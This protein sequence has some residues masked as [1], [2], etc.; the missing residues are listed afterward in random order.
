MASSRFP[1]HQEP[2]SAGFFLRCKRPLLADSGSSPDPSTTILN[3]GY[4]PGSSRQAT[5][6][7]DFRFRPSADTRI[8]L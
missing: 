7:L 5:Q 8:Y 2:A 6:G 1:R 3:G 4:R